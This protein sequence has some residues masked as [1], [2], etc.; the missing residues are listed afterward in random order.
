[1][2]SDTNMNHSKRLNGGSVVIGVSSRNENR[3]SRQIL[4]LERREI[5]RLSALE[6]MS[7]SVS[8]MTGISR[9][10]AGKKKIECVEVLSGPKSSLRCYV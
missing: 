4:A 3:L 8:D 6:V 2:P 5:S 10:S 9:E 7:Q 1:M